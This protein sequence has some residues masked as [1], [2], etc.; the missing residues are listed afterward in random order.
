MKIGYLDCFSGASGDMIVGA[1]IA[2][3]C[4]LEFIQS[5]VNLLGLPGIRMETEQVARHGL[6]GTQVRFLTDNADQPHRSLKTIERLIDKSQLESQDKPRITAI[7]RRIGEAESKAHGIPLEQVHFHE[8]GALD[9]ICDVVAAVVGF[10]YLGIEKLF[11]SALLL[12]SGVIDAAHGKIPIPAP[13]TQEIARGYPVRRIDAD[14][15]LTTP[16]GAAIIREL[17]EY[18]PG[19]EMSI[20]AIGYGAGT[21]DDKD[22]P[23]LLRLLL[24]EAE[25]EFAQDRVVVVETNIDDATPEE[26]GHLQERLFAAGAL[27]V[28]VSGIM[29]KKN[30]PGF[31]VTVIASM[32]RSEPLAEIVLRE[33]STAGLR[34]RAEVR[35]KLER[36]VETV[37]TEF[38]PVRIKFLFGGDIHKFSPEYDDVV[39]AATAAGVPFS[40]VYGAASRAAAK[41]QGEKK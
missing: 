21:R 1:I 8:V 19:Y 32:E 13:A 10:R 34:M 29:M 18:A 6:L 25:A 40:E 12:G 26:I 28:F 7:F 14:V 22:R 24:G 9:T 27:D 16:T 30:R 35:R 5:Q 11:S 15:E 41:I 3:G 38:G 33:S 4:E 23:N 17:A 31:L 2:A 39:K 37:E 36:R 20:S